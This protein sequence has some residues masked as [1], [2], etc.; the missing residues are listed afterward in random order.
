[1]MSDGTWTTH[2]PLDGKVRQITLGM[3]TLC[4]VWKRTPFRGA[5]ENLKLEGVK[6]SEIDEEYNEPSSGV[7]VGW[8]TPLAIY[9]KREWIYQLTG[10]VER[11][12]NATR[13]EF[14]DLNLQLQKTSKMALQNRMPL[15][16]L[17]LKE[18]R[19][20]GY[21]FRI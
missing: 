5:L 1:M 6:R 4:P 16:M 20:C 18:Q 11:L 15:D 7:K 21:T 19:V 2:L 3:S 13:K 17:F 9:K 14:K 10:Q 8:L 12:A